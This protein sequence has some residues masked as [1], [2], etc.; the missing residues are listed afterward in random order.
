MAYRQPLHPHKTRQ[1]GITLIEAL[2][3]LLILA[4][5]V[6]GL[7]AVQARMLVETR[8]TNSRATA[9]RLIA[10]LADRIRINKAGAQPATP[11][12]LSL[13]SDAAAGTFTDPATMT[14]PTDCSTATNC[15]SAQQA[16]YDVWA[17]RTE[18]ASSLMNGRASISQVSPQQLQVIVAWQLNENSNITLGSAAADQQLAAPL[19]ITAANT[20]TNLCVDNTNTYICHVDYIAIPAN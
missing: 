4:L 17:W 5:G 2:I 12:A 20:N 11:G 3:A 16:A 13:Y 18:V 6:L 1:R 8:T 7:A 9:I 15:S 14:A 10:D 19:Q